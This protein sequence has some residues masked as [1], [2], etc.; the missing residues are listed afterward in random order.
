MQ[1]SIRCPGGWILSPLF[2]LPMAV[3]KELALFAAA[4]FLIGGAGDLVVDLIW[5][6]RSSWRGVTVY[7]RHRRANAS[8]IVPR[9]PG[10]IV[11]FVA[12]WDESAV[13]GQMLTRACYA[14]GDADWL[15][16]VGIYPND[17][18]TAAAVAAVAA[19][20]P[21]I[22]VTTGPRSGPTTKADCLNTLWKA[23]TADEF[24]QG[25]RAKAIV[26]HDAE[27][28]I[29][30]GEFA[31]YDAMIERFSLVQIP[32][33]PLPDVTSRWISGHYMDEF[34]E[35]HGKAL[36]VREAIG[37]AIPSAGTGSAFGRATLGRIAEEQGGLPFNGESLTED[38]ELGLRI[39]QMGGRAAFVRLPMAA[40]GAMVAVRAH[41][42]NTLEAAVRQKARWMVG[43]AF[44]GWDRLGWRQGFSENWMRVH[45]R[46]ALIAALVLLAAYAAMLLGFVLA[47][48]TVLAGGGMPPVDPMLRWAIGA[49]FLL[50]IWRLAMRFCFVTASYGWRE[51]LFSIPRAVLANIVA[52]IATRRALSIYLRLRRDGV[53]RWDKTTHFFP[54]SV[55]AD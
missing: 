20:E 49:S 18:A 28:V 26:L 45:D 13:I 30:R 24:S 2:D 7:R 51:G 36:V 27:D 22:R 37:A 52:M 42:P 29:H 10:R 32:V 12:A 55:T 38:Y 33:L 11:I 46:R 54:S 43:I 35:S 39:A 3:S 16:Y 21:R 44:S 34:A 14:L 17:P 23:M 48:A 4:G 25:W 47:V 8:T 31:V 15:L 50:M 41:F 1:K 53:V 19:T 9:R 5:L 40:G 6:A